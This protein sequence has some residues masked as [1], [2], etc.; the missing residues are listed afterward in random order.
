[1][2]D[3]GIIPFT[4]SRPNRL[5]RGSRSGRVYFLG[6]A[7]GF[8]AGAFAASAGFFAGAFFGAAAF[9]ATVF[10]SAFLGAAA[11]FGAAAFL[12]AGLATVFFALAVLTLPF[13]AGLE[14][15]LVVLVGIFI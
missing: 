8:L 6:F 15:L 4:T 2:L 13:A 9:F 3:V 1:M 14:A 7:A 10:A 5:V 11:F 12:A